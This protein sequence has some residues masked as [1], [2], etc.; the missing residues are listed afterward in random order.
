[1]SRTNY[2]QLLLHKLNRL[3]EIEEELASILLQLFSLQHLKKGD[4]FAKA[5]EYSQNMGFVVEGILRAYH[6]TPNGD[7]YN[8][9]FFTTGNFAGAYSSL[10]TGQKNLI[11][12][13]CLT[14]VILLQCQYSDFTSL[15]EEHQE[16]ERMARIIAEQYFVNKETREIQLVT[17]DASDRYK[18]FREHHPNIEQQI[19]QYHIA[20]YLGITPTQLSR[21]RAKK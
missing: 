13:E 6:Q 17:L 8:K 10:V 4:H 1:M 16:V 18:I 12:I 7:T 20:S 3:V 21:I 2:Q 19:P 9:H 5:G 14:D 15:Y 11:D